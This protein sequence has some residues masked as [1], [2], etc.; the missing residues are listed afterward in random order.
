MSNGQMECRFV[1][2]RTRDI[3]FCGR[4][5]QNA[6]FFHE[7]PSL[8]GVSLRLWASVLPRVRGPVPGF[9]EC[10]KGKT[11]TIRGKLNGTNPG[12]AAPLTA[13][14]FQRFGG[15]TGIRDRSCEIPDPAG[16]RD[17]GDCSLSRSKTSIA[18]AT[19]S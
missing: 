10:K 18:L 3:E 11:V 2:Q 9:Q 5:L 15:R 16:C 12:T 1:R 19:A 7:T 14:F 17:R 8:L 6:A 13:M 4:T